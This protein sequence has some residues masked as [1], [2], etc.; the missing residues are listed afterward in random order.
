ML[1]SVVKCCQ[2]IGCVCGVSMKC[3]GVSVVCLRS[4]FGVSKSVAKCCGL[5]M[6]CC[7]VLGSLVKGLC[8]VMLC[9]GVLWVLRGAVECLCSVVTCCGMSME[10]C[11]VSVESVWSVVQYLGC[12]VDC[13]LC[14]R[15][16]G[17]SWCAVKQHGDKHMHKPT[18]D[19]TIST[20][21]E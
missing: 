19:L 6:E 8:N 4:A 12:A 7:E 15:A 18:H 13:C 21:V 2:V 20:I 5:S 3:C 16:H 10:F 11:G 14:C 9:C 1:E 17:V